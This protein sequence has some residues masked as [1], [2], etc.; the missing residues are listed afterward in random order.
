VVLDAGAWTEVTHTTAASDGEKPRMSV[1]ATVVEYT[2]AADVD[3][4]EVEVD[5]PDYDA[6]VVVTGI[7]QCVDDGT[8]QVMWTI[9]VTNTSNRPVAIEVTFD[10]E[11]GLEPESFDWVDSDD[12]VEFTR[13]QTGLPLGTHTLTAYATFRPVGSG[14][15]T[16]LRST[17]GL[18]ENPV[19]PEE[20]EDVGRDE[21]A[22]TGTGAG[23]SESNQPEQEVGTGGGSDVPDTGQVDQASDEDTLERAG[24]V[25]AA[26]AENMTA[27]AGEGDLG[28]GEE[29]GDNQQQGSINENTEAVPA[30]NLENGEHGTEETGDEQQVPDEE[31][32]ENGGENVGENSI[33]AAFEGTGEALIADECRTRTPPTR[34]TPRVD[35][36][37]TKVVD[38]PTPAEGQVVTFTITVT[39]LGPDNARNVALRDLMPRGLT[40][41]EHEVSR[42]TFDPASG[43]WVVGDLDDDESATLTLRMRVDEGT[44]GLTLV[45]EVVIEDSDPEDRN[46]D[47]NRDSAEVQPPVSLIVEEEVPLAEPPAAEAPP[48]PVTGGSLALLVIPGLGLLGAGVYVR[49]GYMLKRYYRD[50]RMRR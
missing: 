34:R 22:E 35:L 24:A 9:R 1:A 32:S 50:L 4:A 5:C 14:D 33:I 8:G 29:Q 36:A 2:S 47:N 42:G 12:Y 3:N 28:D 20:P 44:G 41:V 7:G 16:S 27:G 46:P 45:N 21:P 43:R 38:D 49:R 26:L 48:L 13:T 40:Y 6:E 30:A 17:G 10:E 39:N 37:V 23:D 31:P 18:P 25:M 11:T 15:T 19:E